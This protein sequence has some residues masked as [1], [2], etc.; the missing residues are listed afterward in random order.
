[1]KTPPKAWSLLSCVSLAVVLSSS[2]VAQTSEQLEFFESRIRP[3]LVQHCY[4]CHSAEASK[5]GKL[6]GGR[7]LDYRGKPHRQMCSLFLS[8]MDKFDIRLDRFGDS[9]SRLEE[10]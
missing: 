9:D 2:L 8:L 7:I 6:K 4:K 10:V 1:M 3:V 5:A